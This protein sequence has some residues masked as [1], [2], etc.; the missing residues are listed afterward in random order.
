MD[1]SALLAAGEHALSLWP[2]L[3]L[4]AGVTLGLVVGSIPGLNDTITLAVLVPITFAMPSDVAFPLLVGVYCAACFGGA[5]PAILLK[6]PGTASSVLTAV[7][8]HAMVKQ[9]LAGRALGIATYSSCFAGTLSALVLVFFAPL[10]AQYALKFGPAEYFSLCV[11]GLSTVVGMGS[12]NVMKCAFSCLLG[13]LVAM[14]GL[15]PESGYPRFTF[16]NFWLL[17][18]LPLTPILI[19]L[20]G[21]SV[22]IEMLCRDAGATAEAE[23]EHRTPIRFRDMLLPWSLVRRLMPTWLSASALGNVIGILP[24]AGM[25]VAIYMAYERVRRRFGER[26]GQGL[27]EGIA[28]PEAANNSVVA[29]SMVPLLS[30]GIPGN[31]TS[32]LFL[33]ALLI[34]GLRP[35]PSLFNDS[36]DV[37]WLIVICFVFANLVMFPLGLLLARFVPNLIRA[38]PQPLLAAAIAGLCF[39]GA[40]AIGNS[41]FGIVVAL[42]FGVVGFV[43]NRMQV[44][45]SPFILALVLAPVVERAFFQSMALSGGSPLYFV[46]QPL[47]AAMLTFT[48]LFL[49]WPLFKRHFFKSRRSLAA[50]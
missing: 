15:S 33:G 18:G 25:L 27:P 34:Q 32:A 44:P 48:A 35:G 19:G 12:G 24:G 41:V 8:G 4:L 20:F 45:L 22:V 46:T 38:I 6:I 43:F 9:G 39:T 14:V 49:L 7:D 28:A 5:F 16:D 47:S 3:S 37:A 29:S 11:L 10:L 31:S 21:L 50:D 23:V 30:L 2:L 17:E 36:P 40:F 13:L 26:C 1:Y 42:V